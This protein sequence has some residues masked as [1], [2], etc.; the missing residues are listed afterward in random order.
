MSF[1]QS[2]TIEEAES[3]FE[4]LLNHRQL[5]SHC[6]S[7]WLTSAWMDHIMLDH[8][9]MNE[10]GFFSFA[11]SQAIEEADCLNLLLTSAWMDHNML[12]HIMMDQLF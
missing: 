5:R 1:A 11:R 3:L 2:Q 7:L 9:M 8:I 6:L 12:D 4:P 10:L